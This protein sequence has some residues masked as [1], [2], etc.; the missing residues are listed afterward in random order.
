M[1][2]EKTLAVLG[3]GMMGGALTRGLVSSGAMPAS[4]IR[5]FDT[6]GAK[7]EALASE[8]GH[9]AL[10]M[11]S[12]QAA[13]TDADLILVAVKPQIVSAALTEAAPLVSPS[14]LVISIAAGFPIAKMEA[15]LPD[16]IPVIR[17]MPNTPCLVGKGA[18]ALSRGTHATEAHLALAQSLFAAV[19]LSV[20]VP[21]RLLDAV[22]GLSGSGPAYVYL[23]IEA[24]TDGG[25][26]EGLPRDTARLL[27]A[28]TVL[29]AAQMVTESD[30]HPAQLKDNV[31][32][33]GGTT[34]TGLHVLERAGLRAALMDAVHAA[35]ERARE[36]S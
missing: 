10:T 35:A 5:L 17:A 12:A 27:A 25:V 14:Q 30:L 22:T 13:V 28:Q 15:L 4:G 21:E 32:T 2:R 18:T 24:L 36:M 9:G 11:N 8:L 33:P 20:E 6:D 3:A 7:A 1:L 34:I 23:F 31:T 26:K 16:G 19:G 29:G